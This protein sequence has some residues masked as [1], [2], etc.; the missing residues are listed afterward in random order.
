MSKL[1]MRSRIAQAMHFIDEKTGGVVPPLYTSTTF[2]RDDNYEPR[3]GYTYAR[4]NNPTVS[5]LEGIL[6][7]L[8]GGAD[9]LCFASGLG[10]FSTLFETVRTGA[11]IAIPRI[12][13]HGG[14]D[15]LLNISKKRNIGLSFY[16]PGDLDSLQ[17]AI[18]PG[19]TQIVWVET[20]S[21]PTWDITD[22]AG[23][24]DIAHKAGAIL[25]VDSTCAPP[26]TTRALSYGADVVF[27]SATK[28][29]NGHSDLTAG[30]LVGAQRDDLWQEIW[31]NRKSLGSIIGNFEAWLLIRGLRT[32]FIRFDAASRNAMQI[33]E[34]FEGHDRLEKVLYPGLASHPGHELA[35]RQMTGGF[36]GMMSL[37]VKADEAGAR[38]ITSN[39]KLFLPATSLGG[40]E[41]LAEHRKT[42]EGPNSAVPDNLIRLSVGIEDAGDLI[43][44]I[45]QALASA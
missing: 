34:H 43:A 15:W 36:G 21:N 25:G 45:E 40:A 6:A 11:H 31:A 26:T 24:A 8:D 5:Q 23:A 18:Q 14:L 9:A 41:S 3:A 22:I 35:A 30:V 10:A 13:Y 12:M 38:Q 27:H 7:E 16:K 1:E 42:V 4:Y 17:A 44:D 20:P 28:Y 2:A 33:A 37:M 29:L 32:L 19:K 39:L